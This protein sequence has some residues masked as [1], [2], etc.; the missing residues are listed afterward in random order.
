MF[1]STALNTHFIW[2]FSVSIW[3][4]QSKCV[5]NIDSNGHRKKN[6]KPQKNVLKRQKLRAKKTVFASLVKVMLAFMFY[7]Y[8]SV[9][10]LQ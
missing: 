7:I 3:F 9:F 10:L 5:L 1:L 2:P 8:I 6:K 4:K